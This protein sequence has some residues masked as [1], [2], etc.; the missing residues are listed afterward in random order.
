[1]IIFE[2]DIKYSGWAK[3][4]LVLSPIVLVVFGMLFSL[5]SRGSNIFPRESVRESHI[6]SVVLFASAVFVLAVFWLVFPRKIFVS[7]AG[8]QIK[9]GLFTWNIPFQSIQSIHASKGIIVWWGSSSITSYN[10]QIE[11]LKKSGFKIRVSPARRDQF[12]EIA[13]RALQDRRRTHTGNS[14]TPSS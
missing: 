6:A 3:F 14:A 9:Y 4:M 8:I 2:D 5:N 12:L 13:N 10:H 11:I 7:Q 1:M